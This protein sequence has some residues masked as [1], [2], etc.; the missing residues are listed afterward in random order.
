M[1][2]RSV[3]DVLMH[4]QLPCAYLH[5]LEAQISSTCDFFK[6]MVLNTVTMLINAFASGVSWN[7]LTD[8]WLFLVIVAF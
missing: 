2:E 3:G 1:Q 7:V 4:C 8:T 5:E 6:G